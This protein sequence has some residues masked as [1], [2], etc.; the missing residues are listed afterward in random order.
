MPDISY[1]FLTKFFTDYLPFSPTP[2]Q[3]EVF[4]S[5]LTLVSPFLL[6]AS[7][8]EVKEGTKGQ[9]LKY[10]PNDWRPAIFSVYNRKVAEHAQLFPVFHSFENA[11]RSTVAVTLEQHYKHAR[12][13]RAIYEELK[14]GGKAKNISQIGGVPLARHAAFRIGTIIQDMEGKQFPNGPVAAMMNG[15]EFMHD[16]N[17]GHIR[18]LIEEH[19]T[20]FSPKFHPLSVADFTAKFDKV[21]EA[22]NAVYHHR[23]LSGMSDV[24]AAAEELLD[25]LDFCLKFVHGKVA[26]CEPTKLSFSVDAEKRH[27]TWI[28]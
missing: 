1:E 12:W 15:Y 26:E 28:A 13:W 17:L 14:K 7:L 3:V 27:R 11:L 5:D 4:Q 10:R 9:I 22:R 20:I 6:E 21:R 18:Q 25:K 24:V 23:S 2:S 19:W 8:I 16:C